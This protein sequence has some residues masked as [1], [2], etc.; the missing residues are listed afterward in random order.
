MQ[1]GDGM[2]GYLE[3]DAEVDVAHHDRLVRLLPRAHL[4]LREHV[5]EELECPRLVPNRDELCT[6][7]AR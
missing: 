6:R 4:P 5:V 2:L 7:R 1:R 3:V